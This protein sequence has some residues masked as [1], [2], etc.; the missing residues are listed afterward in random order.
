MRKIRDFRA[1]QLKAFASMGVE[2]KVR[3]SLTAMLAMLALLALA[4][5]GVVAI[6]QYTT[7]HLVSSRIQPTVQI[8][9][10]VDGYRESMRLATKVRWDLISG[11]EALDELE[12]RERAI[13]QAWTR[14][15]NGAFGEEFPRRM[16]LLHRARVSADGA[17]DD[18]RSQIQQFNRTGRR[19]DPPVALHRQIDPLLI[20]SEAAAGEMR[21]LART[22]LVWLNIIQIAALIFCSLLMLAAGLFVRWCIGYATRDFLVPLIALAQYAMPERRN[23][24][25]AQDLGL[26]RRDEIG[27][28]ARAI[29]RS[30]AKAERAVRAEQDRRRA[31]LEL[32]REQL[33]WQEE[34]HRR[35]VTIDGLFASYEA[36]LSQLSERL[37]QAAIGMR[38][39]AQDMQRNAAQHQKFSLSFAERATRATE[40][41]KVIDRH[42]RRLRETGSGVRELVADSSRNIYDAHNASR[43]SRETTDQLQEVAGEISG[44][45]AMITHI[46]KQTN[47]LALN[48]TIEA[49]RAGEAGRGFAVVAQEVKNLASQT[50]N[51]AASVEQR[52]GC[53]ASMTQQVSSAVLAVDGHVDMIRHNADRIDEAVGEQ[54][55]A[56]RDILDG[57]R[58]LLANSDQVTAQVAELTDKSAHAHVSAEALSATAEDVA[59]QS[60]ELRAQMQ[61]LAMAVRAA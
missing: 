41:M 45:L 61:Q 34:R 33:Q 30:H 60:Q 27:A 42:G 26:R 10:L 14:I 36:K 48:A 22:T 4:A 12:T 54:H 59:R 38:E 46:A 58:A 1:N 21:D 18:L 35:A 15:E 44:I 11:P 57:L 47:L 9:M 16:T 13:R 56:S 8:Q 2:A 5:I 23:S 43:L 24:V 53:I 3:F 50:Q 7:R 28:I 49:A 52:L 29:H 17:I 32:Q 31:E 20:Q 40:S 51:A 39:G 25:K 19:V 6:T 37:T 55:D